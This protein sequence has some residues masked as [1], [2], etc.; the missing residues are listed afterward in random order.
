M[1]IGVKS[2]E[3]ASVQEQPFRQTLEVDNRVSIEVIG[4]ISAS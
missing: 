3:P 4:A 2:E 1:A